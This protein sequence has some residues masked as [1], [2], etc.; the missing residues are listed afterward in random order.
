MK[1]EQPYLPNFLKAESEARE[2]DIPTIETQQHLARCGIRFSKYASFSKDPI[3]KK[4][5]A[6]QRDICFMLINQK[7]LERR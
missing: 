6:K 5:M 2:S 7:E 1:P 3:F 4:R